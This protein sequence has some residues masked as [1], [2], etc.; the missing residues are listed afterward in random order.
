M[1]SPLYVCMRFSMGSSWRICIRFE[2]I[3]V[4]TTTNV[5]YKTIFYL[6]LS[7]LKKGY[8]IVILNIKW[9]VFKQTYTAFKCVNILG[10]GMCIT[11]REWYTRILKKSGYLIIKK[12]MFN[13]SVI[14]D[15]QN[16][17]NVRQRNKLW[18]TWGRSFV[19]IPGGVRGTQRICS[20]K[21]LFLWNLQLAS[22]KKE[23][24][25]L[26]FFFVFFQ[27]SDNSWKMF[28]YLFIE[29]VAL[30]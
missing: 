8:N 7:P 13:L 1:T 25:K 27:F 20:F 15:I 21:Y 11:D 6:A 30:F 10:T 14:K 4:V 16:K 29:L 3:P 26:L 23:Q 24:I 2:N 17:T 18:L 28:W 5:C 22:K 12:I 9:Q 19:L